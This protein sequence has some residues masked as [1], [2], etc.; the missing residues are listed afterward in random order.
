MAPS[1]GPMP[2]II[3]RKSSE[4]EGFRRS[5]RF[6]HGAGNVAVFALLRA[7]AAYGDLLWLKSGNPCSRKGFRG[8][9]PVAVC[10]G[11]R[12]IR[13]FGRSLAFLAG[14]PPNWGPLSCAMRALLRRCNRTR[15]PLQV[16]SPGTGGNARGR[17]G[18]LTQLRKQP[19]FP[20]DLPRSPRALLGFRPSISLGS[21]WYDTRRRREPHT[22]IPVLWLS[23]EPFPALS[24]WPALPQ[25][26]CCA[27][28]LSLSSVPPDGPV[29]V[30]CPFLWLVL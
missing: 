16:E 22:V 5:R 21:G 17:T 18:S 20:E 6:S 27:W 4:S 11:L 30:P 8:F 24:A 29:F 12:V 23:P 25:I 13:S 28:I 3:L 15:S 9:P 7:A 10:C 26:A 19:G 14:S 1:D 2:F